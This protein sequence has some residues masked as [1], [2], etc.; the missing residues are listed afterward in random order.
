MKNDR[1]QSDNMLFPGN[2]L[3]WLPIPVLLG[4][5]VIFRFI[6]P[7][8]SFDPPNLLLALNLIFSLLIS[9]LIAYLLGRSFLVRAVPG[10]ALIVTGV[11]LWGS[12]AITG[13]V[14]SNGDSNSLITIH[15]ICVYFSALCYLSGSVLL[16][17]QKKSLNIPGFWLALASLSAVGIVGLIAISSQSGWVPAFFVQGQGGTPIRWMMLISAEV[18]F[19]AAALILGPQ[20]VGRRSQF[21]YFYSMG[22]L[23]IAAGLF[24]IMLEKV[25][26][27]A[28]SWT[29]RIAQFLS[30]IYFLA[31]ALASVRESR[32]WGVSLEKEL[33][34]SRERFSAFMDNS[35]GIAWIKDEEGKHVYLSKSFESRFG[36]KFEDFRGKTDFELWP[37]DIARVFRDNDLAV[38]A[39][40]KTRTVV[41]EARMPDAT[42]TCW[43]N[44]KFLIRDNA[45]RKYVAGS[46]V[47]ITEKVESE[48]KLSQSEKKFRSVLD[49]SID[50]IYRYNIQA[51]KYEYF[52]PACNSV[53][54]F[55]PEE[56]MAMKAEESFSR[57][58][59]DDYNKVV[60]SVKILNE[61]GKNSVELRWLAKDGSY[62]WLS[63]NMHL[64]RD[65]SGRP[66]YRDGVVRDITEK[67]ESEKKMIESEVR[68]KAAE[69][70]RSLI[71]TSLD[72]LVT[73]GP[74][75]KIRDINKATEKA[76]G[77]SREKLIGTDFSDYF[78]EPEKAKAGYEKAF[79]EGFVRDY[80]LTIRHKSGKLASVLYN[81]SVYKD[82]SGKTQGVFA[83]ARDIT[84]L[85]N[86]E[87]AMGRMK[88]LSDIGEL[89]ATVAHELRNPLSGIKVANYNIR[90]KS[91]ERHDLEKHLE[92][93]DKKIEDS[94]QII[95]NLLVFS[96][97]KEPHFEKIELNALLLGEKEETL[98]RY[99]LRKGSLIYAGDDSFSGIEITADP[100]QLREVIHNVLNNSVHA[101]AAK[102]DGRIEIAG[103]TLDGTI[104]II[105]KDNGVGMDIQTLNKIFE[106]FFTTKAKGTGLGMAVVKQ[107]IDN[108]KGNIRVESAEGQGT[109][110]FISLPKSQ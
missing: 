86:I 39:D 83:A 2:R 30:G 57:V 21:A 90:R 92:T 72:P 17:R 22:L 14:V 91:A 66:L 50:A 71:E 102:E 36:V 19:V 56:M 77:F 33:Q 94:N 55:T 47:D 25:H 80:P 16:I 98:E 11:L 54:G 68:R 95:N 110:V 103:K 4:L 53:Y 51:D 82:E 74:D 29:G 28:L 64:F 6:N 69:Y 75:G 43:L 1:Q 42:V 24:G 97:I 52:S 73:I 93:I 81:A 46:G 23:L 34:E 20:G 76:T 63:T 35:P 5:I 61:L 89:A 41:E 59:R 10:I 84:E 79:N 13:L 99:N 67:V 45:G 106:P 3:A 85:K 7:Q 38:L 27:N 49:N 88:R 40:G 87:Q 100:I 101:I 18:M 58:H 62:R 70:A 48:K 31:A 109:S 108:H 65:E 105:I 26:G 96:N 12:A 32:V 15:N 9:L 37:P 78:T 8:S 60:S 104:E 107:I 44:S